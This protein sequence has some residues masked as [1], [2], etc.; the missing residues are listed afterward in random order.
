[1]QVKFKKLHPDAVLPSYAHPGDNGL[2]LT[3]ISNGKVTN[4]GPGEPAYYFVEFE[5]GVAVELPPGHVGLIF[6]RSSISKTALSLANSVGV[7]D[8]AYRGEIK[9]RF[10]IDANLINKFPDI[11]EV[12]I[13]KKG[14]RI[15]QLI[16]MPVPI[17]EPEWTEELK[18]TER[19]DQGFGSTGN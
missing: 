6:P 2:D 7:I 13:Y 8:S 14:D 5:T 19:G 12:A 4:S 18:E 15:G 11:P 17:I 1:M 3:A 10:K 9:F 16:I